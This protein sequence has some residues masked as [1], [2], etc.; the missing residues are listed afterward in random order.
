MTRK[1]Q[2]RKQGA[3][4]RPDLD[5]VDQLVPAFSFFVC[6]SVYYLYPCCT[7]VSSNPVF[8]RNP[9][10]SSLALFFAFILWLILCQACLGSTTCAARST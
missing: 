2:G 7:I 3:A 10:C 4:G 6:Y 1:E 9:V 8:E 5:A